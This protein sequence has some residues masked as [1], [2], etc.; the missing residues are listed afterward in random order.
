[1]VLNPLLRKIPQGITIPRN[2]L[3]YVHFSNHTQIVNFVG[4]IFGLW[5]L[6]LPASRFPITFGPYQRDYVC[7][8]DYGSGQV[9][10]YSRS[11]LRYLDNI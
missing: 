7:V 10:T 11:K 1:M 2:P 9:L 6:M 5:F 8:P 4:I 3:T